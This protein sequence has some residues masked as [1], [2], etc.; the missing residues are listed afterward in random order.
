[1]IGEFVEEMIQH[2]DVTWARLT[3][4]CVTVTPV[5]PAHTPTVHLTCP[6]HT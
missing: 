2:T 1:M 6:S 4:V 3:M 5:L